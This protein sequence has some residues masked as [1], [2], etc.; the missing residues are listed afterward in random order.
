MQF[1][2][3]GIPVREMAKGMGMNVQQM[4]LLAQ[5]GKIT[6]VQVNAAFKA[7]SS[8]GGIYHNAMAESMNTLSTSTFK[9]RDAVEQMAGKFGDTLMK[10]LPII[11]VL[12]RI[13]N[14]LGTLTDKMTAFAA[15][16]PVLTKML[17]WAALFAAALGPVI[18]AVGAVM[19]GIG[20]VMAA[21][22]AVTAAIG[23]LPALAAFAGPVLA[24]AAAF[25]AW[26]VAVGLFIENWRT[27]TSLGG[28]K[29]AFQYIMGTQAKYTGP[30][31]RPAALGGA[32]G[33]PGVA[34]QP[35]GGNSSFNGRLEIVAPRGSVKKMSSAS[36][37]AG[38]FNVGMKMAGAGAY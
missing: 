31:Q 37:G 17:I 18:A 20:A 3:A 26:A 36:T 10:A 28:W 21:L 4:M 8:A 34:T 27:L 6:S 23:V 12:H 14:T 38:N 29:D 15:A 30:Q 19:V 9:A 16:H 33:G 13:T 11:P 32:A 1:M 2:R 5:K 22:P 25:T 7:M 35:G 24:I